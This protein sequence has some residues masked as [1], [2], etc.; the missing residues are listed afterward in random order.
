MTATKASQ[1]DFSAQN[2]Y[3][4]ISPLKANADGKEKIRLTVFILD[5]RGLGISG[6]KISLKK[7]ENITTEAVQNI[8]DGSGKAVFDVISIKDGDYY[9]EVMVDAVKSGIRAHLLFKKP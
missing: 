3:V 4:F 6:R 5:G 8:T 9:L 7:T 1:N 2:S